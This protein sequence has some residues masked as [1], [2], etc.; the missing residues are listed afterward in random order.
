MFEIAYVVC[1]IVIVLC[2]ILIGYGIRNDKGHISGK[3]LFWILFWTSI[4]AFVPY[5]NFLAAI[6]VAIMFLFFGVDEL[7]N[8]KLF[9]KK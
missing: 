6:M 3:D 2:G 1:A 8:F 7:D 9:Q 5:L 4:L